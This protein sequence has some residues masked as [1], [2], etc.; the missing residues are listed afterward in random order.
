MR[1]ELATPRLMPSARIFG[2]G[3]EDVVAHELHVLAQALREDLPA[4]PVALGHAVLDGDDRVLVAPGREQVGELLRV[5]GELLGL[6]AVLAVLVELARRAVEAEQHVGARRGSP[7][8]R[9]PSRSTGSRASLVGRL[10][11]KPPSSPTA[12]DMPSLS[13]IFFSVWKI[14]LPQRSASRNDVKPTGSTMNS[15]KSRLL[16]A[17]APPLITF[18]IGTGIF[19]RAAAAEVAVER[20]ARLLGRR[21][22]AGDRHRED[23]VG[24][25]ARL[26]LGAVQLDQHLVDVRLLGGVEAED[27]L[28]DLGVHVLDRLHARPCRRSAGRRR[29]AARSPRASRWRRPRAPPRGPCAPDS[30]RTS[31]STVGLPRESRISRASDFDDGGH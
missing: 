8:P 22:G 11:A 28:A 13:I 18:I 24:A 5:V 9:S 1:M 26:V 21:L 31:A 4:V 16:L 27:R 15:W 23:G 30:S 25:E 10:G 2:V 12:V 3:D 19:L 14:S 29:R 17:C 7:P 20:E 6:E